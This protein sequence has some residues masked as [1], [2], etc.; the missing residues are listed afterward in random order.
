MPWS[1]AP[2]LR[3]TWAALCWAPRSGGRWRGR[4]WHIQW[5]N[6][7][8]EPRTPGGPS[9][10]CCGGTAGE[11]T[12]TGCKKFSDNREL[13]EELRCWRPEGATSGWD[14][15]F[16]RT[17]DLELRD[18]VWGLGAGW[19]TGQPGSWPG[20]KGCGVMGRWQVVRLSGGGSREGGFHLIPLQVLSSLGPRFPASTCGV[21]GA[22]GRMIGE[23][24]EGPG[25]RWPPDPERPRAGVGLRYLPPHGLLVAVI[26]DGACAWLLLFKGG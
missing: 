18:G 1:P 7:S 11:R 2:H 26:P 3:A 25:C 8:T 5:E 13:S 10:L 23:S 17:E 20:V 24:E 14:D 22:A 16:A 21:R 4:W 6:H 15:S 12:G 19:A 9:P